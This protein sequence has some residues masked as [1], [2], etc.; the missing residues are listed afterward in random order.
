MNA[1]CDE[2]AHKLAELNA[3]TLILSACSLVLK[4]GQHPPRNM[5][6]LAPDLPKLG[7]KLFF[8][9]DDLDGLAD[10]IEYLD[11]K[12]MLHRFPLDVLIDGKPASIELFQFTGIGTEHDDLVLH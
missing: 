10:S 12:G 9:A 4:D 5:L 8:Y 7:S 3:K 2:L 6:K 1:R 11:L